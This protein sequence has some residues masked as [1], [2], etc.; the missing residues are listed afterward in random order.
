MGSAAVIPM[1]AQLDASA[2]TDLMNHIKEGMTHT[3]RGFV[4]ENGNLVMPLA[5]LVGR[6]TA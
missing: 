1:L 4:T 2:K 6:A 5:A 3:L